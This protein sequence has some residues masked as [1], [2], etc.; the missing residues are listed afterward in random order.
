[1]GLSKN[2]MG[3][4]F[5]AG[6]AKAINGAV[7]TGLTAAGTVIG[8][9]LDLTADLNIIGT[10]AASTGVQ[11]PSCEVG[12]SCQIYNGGANAVKV[13]PDSSSNTIN[14]LSA[15]SAMLLATNTA[16]QYFKISSTRWV[17]NLSA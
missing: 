4:G 1:M 10:A 11:L 6:Q 5:S 15:G 13:Y 2:M 16:C 12:D 14:Q 3:G 17:A 7:A 8:D 9:A